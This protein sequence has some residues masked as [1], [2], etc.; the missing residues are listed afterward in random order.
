MESLPGAP[1]TCI[2]LHVFVR[3]CMRVQYDKVSFSEQFSFISH[4][5]YS[6][7]IERSDSG[8]LR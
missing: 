6:F 3:A 2:C 5:I 1:S 8:T 7:T 4:Q